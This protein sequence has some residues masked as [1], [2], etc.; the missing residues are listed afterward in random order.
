MEHAL[1]P[2]N[3][4]DD[5]EQLNKIDE[6]PE[7]DDDIVGSGSSGT[8]DS[9]ALR[10]TGS[11]TNSMLGPDQQPLPNPSGVIS[12]PDVRPLTTT[13]PAD[14][15]RSKIGQHSRPNHPIEDDDVTQKKSLS[16]ESSNT[17][18]K[19]Q[20][21]T[22]KTSS[23]SKDISKQ[24]KKLYLYDGGNPQP[25]EPWD[26]AV[27]G[28]DTKLDENLLR[29]TPSTTKKKLVPYDG[30]QSI[31]G[32][33]ADSYEQSIHLSSDVLPLGK[34]IGSSQKEGKDRPKTKK[35]EDEGNRF[36][37]QSTNDGRRRFKEKTV[38]PFTRTVS[39]NNDENED[40]N[41]NGRYNDDDGDDD[42]I[43]TVSKD[44]SID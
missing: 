4:D 11:S 23:S 32:T 19:E 36:R 44:V 40:G 27:K 2:V 43:D 7:K 25:K 35:E 38:S 29:Q 33:T 41:N 42:S 3:D 6:I 5:D 15:A 9:P 30:S 31:G 16:L 1:E 17:E 22:S 10:K 14:T 28:L 34:E 24:K 21:D 20:D 26:F 12:F 39:D 8:P 13:A 37:Q 18:S